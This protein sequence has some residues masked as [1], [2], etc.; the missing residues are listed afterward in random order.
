M[1]LETGCEGAK[2]GTESFPSALTF[3]DSFGG[4]SGVN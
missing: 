2:G 3:I 4:E 1:I